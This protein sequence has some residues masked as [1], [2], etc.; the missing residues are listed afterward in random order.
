MLGD[1]NVG[2]SDNAVQT[3]PPGG[4]SGRRGP[5]CR[6]VACGRGGGWTVEIGPDV[7]MLEKTRSAVQRWVRWGL[8]QIQARLRHRER[9]RFS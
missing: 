9:L 5:A 2:C 4:R 1:D 6:H 3:L 7:V 8:G